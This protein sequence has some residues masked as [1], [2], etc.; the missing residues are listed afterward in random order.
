ML[1]PGTPPRVAYEQQLA[2]YGAMRNLQCTPS[3]NHGHYYRLIQHLSTGSPMQ[4]TPPYSP[5][6]HRQVAPPRTPDFALHATT[7]QY[8]Y[9]PMALR[10]LTAPVPHG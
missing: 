2:T 6:Y 4:H 5:T 3:P 9:S 1:P 10:K 7:Q 8:Q